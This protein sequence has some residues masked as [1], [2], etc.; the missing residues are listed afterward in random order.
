MAE[1]E[2]GVEVEVVHRLGIRICFLRDQDF[3]WWCFSPILTDAFIEALILLLC[4]I[5]LHLV[6][7]SHDVN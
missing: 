6:K 3:W 1:E 2:E 4:D 5:L 7:L